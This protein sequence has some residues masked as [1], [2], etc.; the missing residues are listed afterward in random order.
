MADRPAGSHKLSAVQWA[1]KINIHHLWSTEWTI[2]WREKFS[3][4]KSSLRNVSIGT[5]AASCLH[6]LS[7]VIF[8]HFTTSLLK[9]VTCFAYDHSHYF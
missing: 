1:R 2:K 7:H 6:T 5:L 8:V 4:G 9:T 3:G